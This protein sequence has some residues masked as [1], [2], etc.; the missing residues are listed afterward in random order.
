VLYLTWQD[1]ENRIEYFLDRCE[2][3][4][5]YGIPRGGKVVEG[6]ITLMTT[7]T[8]AKSPEEA[9]LI[10]DD[11]VDS[12]RTVDEWSKYGV[13]ILCLY[14]KIRDF[15]NEWVVFP[16][17]ES[18]EADIAESV[19]RIIEYIGEDVGSNGLVETPERVVKSWSELYAGY[20]QDPQELLK[21]FKDDTDE[22]V[23]ARDIE[24]YSMCEHHMLPF[25]GK[26]YVGY[27]PNGQ[28][29]GISKIA[30]IV[31]CYARRLQIQERIT[32]QIGE[33]IETGGVLG[34]GVVLKGKHHCMMSRG[35]GK[36]NSDIVTSYMSGVLRDKPEARA[37]FMGLI[38]A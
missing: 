15:E 2:G 38:D 3:K 36:Q 13:P 19:T 1:V 33:A 31:D 12:G 32:R 30:R 4:A 21:W 9:D 6:L 35:V 5:I 8:V 20:N 18:G 27:I 26:A 22:M 25:Y 34:V 24:F 23:I 7:A 16:W 10:I 28:V 14:N 29:L 17:E 11:I 37:E